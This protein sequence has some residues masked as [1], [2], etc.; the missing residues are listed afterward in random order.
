MEFIELQDILI[1]NKLESVMISKQQIISFKIISQVI[2]FLVQRVAVIA[3]SIVFVYTALK[4]LFWPW[5]ILLWWW[6]VGGVLY[7]IKARWG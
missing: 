4:W 7:E 3:L 6:N 2:T 5:L 1:S